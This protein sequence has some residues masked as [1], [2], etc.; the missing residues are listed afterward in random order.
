MNQNLFK[1]EVLKTY[2][3]NC[4]RVT[5]ITTSH[6]AIITPAFMP[7]GTHAAVNCMTPSDLEQTQT[8]IILGGNTYHMLCRPGLDVIKHA[9]GMHQFMA[10][11]GPML[12]DSGGFQVMSLAR[13]QANCRFDTAGAHIRNPLTGDTIHL[14]PRLAYEAQKIIGADITMPFD[15]CVSDLDDK[16]VVNDAMQRT[17]R[18]LRL[19][20]TYHD[21]DAYSEYGYRQALFGIIQ[22]GFFK[23]LRE[24]SVEFI[25]SMELDGIAF[26]GGTIGYEMDKT[27]TIIGWLKRLLPDDKALYTMGVGLRP[28]DIITLSAQGI[29]LYDCV[30]PTRNARHGTLYSGEIVLENHWLRFKS[31]HPGACIHIKKA[32]FAKDDS[33]IMESCDCYTCQHFPRAYLHLLYKEKSITYA[34]LACIHNV[35]VMQTVCRMIHKLLLQGPL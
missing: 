28:Q 35:H 29:D 21:R 19:A 10:W 2:A 3:Y 13:H 6:G 23:D 20:R 27:V 24:E 25:L 4:A 5:R 32:C 14:T 33:P 26:G 1:T 7:V 22:G 11:P 31:E 16:V 17:H 8:Q 18:W 12:T 34:T 30:A 15:H 9:G